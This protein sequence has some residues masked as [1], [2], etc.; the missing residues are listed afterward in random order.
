M[1]GA[2]MKVGIVGMP[3]SGKTAVFRLLTGGGSGV[4]Q[5]ASIGTA[6]VPDA[7]IDVL[8]GMFKPRKTTYAQIE[9]V[10]LA[11]GAGVGLGY[12]GDQPDARARARA[13]SLLV[14]H[15]RTV[16][17]LIHVVRVFDSPEGER[18]K[19]L[20]DLTSLGDELILADMAVAEARA[21]RLGS[22][23][24]RT[25]EEDHELALMDL[26]ARELGEGRGLRQAE[27]SDEDREALRGYG[28]LSV[29]PVVVAANMSEEQYQSGDYPDQAELHAYC[30]KSRIP[31]VGLSAGI[32]AEI[33]ELPQDER[34]AFMDAYGIASTGVEQVSRAVYESLGL[35][36]FFTVGEDEVRAWPIA[37][38]TRA[39]QAAGK[40]HSD[41]EHGF[42]RAE[43]VA[44][45][46]LLRLGSYAAARAAGVF[47]LEGRDYIMADGD[48]VNFRFSPAR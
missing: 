25:A 15:M 43:I 37:A 26:L 4:R 14:N 13:M 36:S 42:I 10:D 2:R 16:D 45:D 47:R 12:G 32:E 29:K 44:Y 40:I 7:R 39:K 46:D 22:S 18:A 8:S 48:I 19:A 24:K 23:R 34:K 38:G 33:S 27:L 31:L 17:A 5:D 3:G 9:V 6:R 41:I 11:G 35:V 1:E 28:L 21:E 30:E 20:S